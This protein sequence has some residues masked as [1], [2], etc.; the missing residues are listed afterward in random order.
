MHLW[1]LL[2]FLIS[3]LAVRGMYDEALHTLEMRMP[4]FEVEK[5]DTYLCTAVE[6]PSKPL[7]LI[8]V[9]PHSEQD[10]VHH[11]LLFGK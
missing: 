10:T 6:L 7:K 11:M 1:S 5:E 4:P 3:S 2:V 8:E 9:E